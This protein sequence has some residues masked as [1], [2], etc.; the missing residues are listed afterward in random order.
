MGDIERRTFRNGDLLEDYF[1]NDKYYPGNTESIDESVERHLQEMDKGGEKPSELSSLDEI[2]CDS[3]PDITLSP[4]RS[5]SETV[6]TTS[7]RGILI[8]CILFLL[9]TTLFGYLLSLV[10]K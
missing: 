10:C 8:V 6:P 9:A 1:K 5:A 2:P 3:D 4:T 7:W